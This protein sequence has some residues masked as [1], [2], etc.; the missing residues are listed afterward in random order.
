MTAFPYFL[1]ILP[2]IDLAISIPDAGDLMLLIWITGMAWR[3]GWM[4]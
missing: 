2:L 4:R 1:L 3:M